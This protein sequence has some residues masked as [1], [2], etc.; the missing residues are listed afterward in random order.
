MEGAFRASPRKMRGSRVD[1]IVFRGVLEKNGVLKVRISGV[2]KVRG[3]E[4]TEY[5][6]V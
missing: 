1:D 2:S 3:Y 6:D 5:E 4:Y